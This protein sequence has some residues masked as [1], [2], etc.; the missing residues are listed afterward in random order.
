MNFKIAIN[1]FK[2]M[3]GVPKVQYHGYQIMQRG[4]APLLAKVKAMIDMH[5]P[6]TVVQLRRFLD[7][8]NFCWKFTG[9]AAYIQA[10]LNELLKDSKRNYK[11]PIVWTTE[12]KAVFSNLKQ[13]LA[14]AACL[15]HP[16]ESTQLIL[17]T[18]ASDLTIG[19][20]LE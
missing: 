16:C 10:P 18:D 12:F 9:A 19:G 14:E 1:T 4:T 2:R 20:V 3:F 5:K 8:V 6:N 13:S 7:A 17:R 11:R 15:A